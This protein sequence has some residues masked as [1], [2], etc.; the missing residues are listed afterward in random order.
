MSANN[1]NEIQ[2]AAIFS[3]TGKWFSFF[4][5]VGVSKG[6]NT[7][8]H[9]LWYREKCSEGFWLSDMLENRVMMN[10]VYKQ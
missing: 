8:I 2:N 9:E 4:A 6:E 3:Y 10:N 5:D 1:F 7:V